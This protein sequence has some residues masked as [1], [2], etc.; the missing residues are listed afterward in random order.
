M[1]SAVEADEVRVCSEFLQKCCWP[2]T[3]MLSAV[4]AEVDNLGVCSLLA[5]LS[6]PPFPC[7]PQFGFWHSHGQV[8]PVKAQIT[9]S[10]A[11]QDLNLVYNTL[12]P[13]L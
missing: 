7:A 9:D 13:I 3:L 6:I 5:L 2:D 8:N 10:D 12:K 11:E 4:C 1:A